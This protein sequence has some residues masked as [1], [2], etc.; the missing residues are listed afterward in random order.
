MPDTAGLTLWTADG[1]IVY[2]LDRSYVGRNFALPADRRRR[3]ARRLGHR[4]SRPARRSRRRIAA[5]RRHRLLRGGVRRRRRPR[6]RT[7]GVGGRP[8]PRQRH[9]RRQPDGPGGR[10]HGGARHRAP[11]SPLRDCS[12][13]ASLKRHDRERQYRRW[14]TQ[15]SAETALVERR[16]IAADLHDGVVQDLTGLALDVAVPT[17]PDS[18]PATLGPEER[19][20][21]RGPAAGGD[22]LAAC[23]DRRA[24]P[25][26]IHS[27]RSADQSAGAARAGRRTIRHRPHAR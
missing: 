10:P 6:R 18:D 14:L 12:P 22:D 24:L 16:R 3:G 2:S 25:R 23:A 9:P 15:R 17:D 21:R 11:S 1:T 27:H 5:R 19:S 26:R 13:A 4:P 8:P 20:A 7:A